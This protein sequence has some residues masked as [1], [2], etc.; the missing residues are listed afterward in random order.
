[1]PIIV[2]KKKIDIIFT[3]YVSTSVFSKCRKVTVIHDIMPLIIRKYPYIRQQFVKFMMFISMKYADKIITVSQNSLKD[4]E[5]YYKNYSYKI[6]YIHNGV[7]CNTMQLIE[8]QYRVKY[9]FS[10]IL[11]VGT[12]QPSKNL[13]RLIKAYSFIHENIYEKLLIVGA[14]GWQKRS[15]LTEKI[16]QLGLQKKILFTGYVDDEELIYL[17]KNA[18][19]L[20]YPSLYE[21]FGFPPLEAMQYGTAVL[22]SNVSSIPEV[23]GD[24]ALYIDPYDEKDISEK[25]LLLC[26]DVDINKNLTIKGKK[27]VKKFTWEKNVQSLLEIFDEMVAK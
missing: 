4:L 13:D 18:K 16:D 5:K 1:M 2:K 19:F 25:M 23:C 14:K 22:A 11:F 17:Y 21:G 9:N 3:P 7:R 15:N 24:A 27:Q 20:A 10:Y 8:K 12:L 26:T 6:S